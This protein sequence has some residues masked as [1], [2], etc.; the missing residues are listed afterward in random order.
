MIQTPCD[1]DE[2]I[3]RSPDIVSVCLTLQYA[4]VVMCEWIKNIGNDNTYILIYLG[5]IVAELC[6]CGYIIVY[7][8]L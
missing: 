5:V 2:V 6:G 8:L 1:F 7:V 4:I 3:G